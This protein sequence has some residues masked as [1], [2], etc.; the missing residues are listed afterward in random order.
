MF[1]VS[2]DMVVTYSAPDS[3]EVQVMSS[4]AIATTAVWSV[5]K[6][7]LAHISFWLHVSPHSELGHFFNNCGI[8]PH[9]ICYLVGI[10]APAFSFNERARTLLH[11]FICT[12]LTTYC[13]AGFLCAGFL[14]EPS[15]SKELS[16]LYMR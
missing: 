14:A 5:L 7:F 12:N 8:V 9:I 6:R 4:S 16:C 2:Q 13:S 3:F 15:M 1:A 10:T 11:E